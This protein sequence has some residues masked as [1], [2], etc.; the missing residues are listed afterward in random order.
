LVLTLVAEVT[1]H[2]ELLLQVIAILKDI[3][4]QSLLLL[5]LLTIGTFLSFS[6]GY[7]VSWELLDTSWLLIELVLVNLRLVGDLLLS[8]SID[9]HGRDL[10]G[11]S[12]HILIE[13]L[14]LVK[15]SIH[16]GGVVEVLVWEGMLNELGIHHIGLGRQHRH[17]L[18][19][20][21]LEV[22]VLPILHLVRVLLV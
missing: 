22:H 8:P 11:T 19:P 17:V 21:I 14:L 3:D 1:R 20:A 6:Y 16:L 18:L 13:G 15:A 2:L 4:V 10:V 9:V 12:E 7:L 5:H